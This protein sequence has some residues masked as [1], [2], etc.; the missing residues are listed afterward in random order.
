MKK[1][2]FGLLLLLSFGIKAQ[3]TF[4]VDNTPTRFVNKFG[5]PVKATV[6]P[7]GTD[8]A[9]IWIDPLDSSFNWAYK[10]QKQKAA[11]STW[12]TWDSIKAKPS[13]FEYTS[14]KGIANGYAP[15]GSDGRISSIYLPFSSAIIKGTW[16]ANT[17][18]PTLSDATGTAGWIYFCNFAGTQNLGSG[19]VSYVAGDQLVHNGTIWE[20]VPNPSSVNSVNGFTGTIV[21]TTNNIGESGT[22]YYWTSTRSRS[23]MGLTTSGSSGAAT[24]DNTTGIYNIP[25]Y[26]LSG[27]GGVAIADTAAMLSS[28]YRTHV[29]VAA[30]ALKL[31]I[32]DTAAQMLAYKIKDISHD[33]SISALNADT[34]TL[35]ARFANV[36]A[37]ANAKVNISDTASM[38]NAYRLKD[39]SH[40][41][42][43]AAKVNI[44]DTASMLNAYRL[45]DISHDAS[46]ALKVNI[47]DTASM[48]NAY[49][50]KDISHDASISSLSSSK[51]NVSDTASM[52]SPYKA[53]FIRSS[54]DTTTRALTLEPISG[55]VV[56][57]VI[58]RGSA[59][60]ATGIS[61]LSSSKSG[62]FVTVAGDNGSNTQFSIQTSDSLT[63]MHFSDTAS[64]L[65]AYRLKDISHDAS[66]AAKV[67]ISDTAS[68]LNAYKLKDISHDASIASVVASDALKVVAN[69]AITGATKTKITYD[70]KG[71]VTTGADA[72]TADIAAST[73]KNY[74]TDAQLVVIGNTSGT[75]TGDNA[76]N[77]LYS[78]LASSKVN[79][80]DTASMLNAYKV[81]DIAQDAAILIRVNYSDTASMLNA[82]R[83]KDI[84]HDASIA[85]LNADTAT[86]AARFSNVLGVANA[87]VNISDTA[88]MLSPYSRDY[89]TVHKTGTETIAGAKEF[90]TVPTSGGNAF[91]L[92]NDSRMTNSRNAADVYAWAKASTKP[93]Y[94]YSELSGTPT[95]PTVYTWAQQATKPSYTYAEIGGSIPTWNQNTT[96]TAASLTGYTNNLSGGPFSGAPDI[97]VG[98][99][100]TALQR[101]N[102][103]ALSSFLTGN[104]LPLSGGTLTGALSISSTGTQLD[105]YK[106]NYFPTIRF[107]GAAGGSYIEG[108]DQWSIYTGLTPTKRIIIDENGNTTL[109]NTSTVGIGT[110]YAGAINGTTGTF[111]NNIR[112]SAGKYIFIDDAYSYLWNPGVALGGTTN[113]YNGIYGGQLTYN[114][115]LVGGVWKG[116][117]GGVANSIWA[118]EG[119]FEFSN[120]S[121]SGADANLS[122]VKRFGIAADGAATFSS[123]ITAATQ[124][125]I[126]NASGVAQLNIDGADANVS[127]IGFMSSGSV[128]WLMGNNGN[129]AGNKWS[130]GAATGLS[131]W[132]DYFSLNYSTGD[133]SLSSALNVLGQSALGQYDGGA[134]I[135]AQTDYAVTIGDGP[136][137]SGNSLWVSNISHFEGAVHIG[138]SARIYSDAISGGSNGWN[139]G[140]V[141]SPGGL[142]LN[143]STY[144]TVNINGTNYKL[145]T[146]N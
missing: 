17:N 53:A 44:S 58:P 134:Q 3:T 111:S 108:G 110:L 143:T 136:S 113:V 72:T 6:V 7:M 146:V 71:L 114:A 68:M 116:I 94:D 84:S 137:S 41:A 55:S 122:W 32:S 107:V 18:T 132:T 139:F 128:K 78:G 54:F 86:L 127:A 118:G 96:G 87:K 123:T 4:K 99:S 11:K 77:S 49:K 89:N 30:L 142:T 37:V 52:L 60:G 76:V 45:K 104:W 2:L 20:K 15:I 73:N 61:A 121:S 26:S 14:N 27:L 109:G 124:S 90:I 48:L 1:V 80:S 22:N 140:G 5:I 112:L 144:I 138:S 100:G 16:N 13:N 42:S 141:T 21:L 8:S 105:L 102:A 12:L 63:R 23:A 131:T 59:S 120:A 24:Y 40:D 75:N 50:L 19:S 115:K 70:A 35:A 57:V 82:Y 66:I 56:S 29:A 38:L 88:S 91:V 133:A 117:A 129:T 9:L 106:A 64:M 81:K 25:Q 28:Y 101:Y 79:V 126:L 93:S 47:S 119:N 98:L 92:T 145:A 97:I 74:V 51:V 31:N 103:T 34:A 125:K 36:L 69:S 135:P 43:I 39:I 85:A 33:A 95:I 62:N 130:I 10:G 67:N 65:N 83:L 46:I